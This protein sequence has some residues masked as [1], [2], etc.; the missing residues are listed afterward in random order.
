MFKFSQVAGES[1]SKL[2][3]VPFWQ[4]FISFFLTFQ[5]NIMSYARLYFPYPSSGTSHFFKKPWFLLMEKGI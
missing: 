5:K 2:P 4:P 3:Y 1:L